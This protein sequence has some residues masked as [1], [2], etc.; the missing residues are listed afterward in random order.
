MFRTVPLSIIRSF[1]LYTQ[2]WYIPCRFADSL[3]AGSGLPLTSCQQTCMTY[4]IAV[5]TVKTPDYIQR[6]CLKHV[7]FYSKNKLEKSV[8]LVG[9]IIRTESKCY[10]TRILYWVIILPLSL[11][12]F[13]RLVIVTDVIYVNCYKCEVAPIYYAFGVSTALRTIVKVILTF[14]LSSYDGQV[15]VQQVVTGSK[16]DFSLPRSALLWFL[17]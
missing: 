7:E 3:R 8:H 17:R 14:S 2:Q 13:G 9:F 10:L 15:R 4:T 5:F 6:N 11:T 12:T 1:S 16:T